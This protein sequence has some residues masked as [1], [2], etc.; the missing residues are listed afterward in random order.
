M[1]T[2]GISVE[3]IEKNLKNTKMEKKEIF[4]EFV[5][6][7]NDFISTEN[8]FISEETDNDYINFQKIQGLN[9]IDTIEKINNEYVIFYTTIYNIN[10]IQK[11]NE[12]VNLVVLKDTQFDF[13]V[14]KMNAK[15]LI[16]ENYLSI[17]DSTKILEELYY[18]D[19]YSSKIQLDSPKKNK[20]FDFKE[21]KFLFKIKKNSSI[22][23]NFN[24]TSCLNL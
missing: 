14:K 16:Q 20:S 24:E 9:N 2:F 18:N 23:K 11:E 10:S 13:N 7:E 6:K 19:S 21:K 5:K 4:R 3:D 1:S 12:K 22:N 17:H 8:F 15:K